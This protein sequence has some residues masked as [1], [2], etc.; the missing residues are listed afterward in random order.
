MGVHHTHHVKLAAHDR[1]LLADLVQQHGARLYAYVRR[2]Y[3]NEHDAE[4]TVAEAFVRAA[5]NIATLKTMDRPEFYLLTIVRNLCR[6]RYRRTR[7]VRLVDEGE[8]TGPLEP[9]REPVTSSD[10]SEA[11]RTAVA[12]LPVHLREVVVL[13]LSTDL[14]FEE[15]ARLLGVPLGTALSRMHSAVRRLRQ[16][17]G[18][19]V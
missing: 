6:D 16:V 9:E 19:T 11:L 7:P 10:E 8:L 1:R 5:E 15:I 18:V 17:L 3:G 13:R 2:T 12:A 14:K 4:D